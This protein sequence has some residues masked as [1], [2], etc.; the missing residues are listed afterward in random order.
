[1]SASCGRGHGQAGVTGACRSHACGERR[2]RRTWG[3]RGPLPR[4]S[5]SIVSLGGTRPA[6]P[7]HPEDCPSVQCAPG[8]VRHVGARTDRPHKKPRAGDCRVM[9][10]RSVSSPGFSPTWFPTWTEG[11]EAEAAFSCPGPRFAR[12]AEGTVLT[13]TKGNRRGRG[14]V[15]CPLSHPSPRGGPP[16]ALHCPY[17]GRGP[18]SRHWLNPSQEPLGQAAASRFLGSVPAP[19]Q[20][21]LE[22]GG[23]GERPVTP[24]PCSPKKAGL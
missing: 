6:Q 19:P 24:D 3:G 16:G 12:G 14:F 13:C 18:R 1:M 22:G 11:T 4:G 7:S 23:L 8:F 15:E 5:R 20:T 10:T 9:K 17:L 2:P 21:G